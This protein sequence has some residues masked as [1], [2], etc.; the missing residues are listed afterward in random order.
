MDWPELPNTGFIFGR[1]AT[2]DDVADGTAVFSMNGQSLGPID[3]I[4]PQYAILHDADS[5]TDEPVILLQAESAP[6]GMSI[7]GFQKS[8]G[9]FAAAALLELT[10]LG[11]EKPN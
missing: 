11:T 3:L 2:T 1:V 8:D 10:L 6:N 7:A 4:I 5:G 9:S